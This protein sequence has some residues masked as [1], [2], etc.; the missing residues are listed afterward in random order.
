M[1]RACEHYGSV[2]WKNQV[3]NPFSNARVSCSICFYQKMA[4]NFP[5][6]NKLRRS[7]ILV[8]LL[9]RVMVSVWA[10]ADDTPPPFFLQDGSDSLCLAGADFKR[11]S[12]HTLWYAV[13]S[14]GSYQ[15]HKRTVDAVA[16]ADGCGDG[17]CVAKKS[18]KEADLSKIDGLKVTKCSHCGAKNWNILGDADTGYV[19]THGGESV[20]GGKTSTGKKTEPSTQT[21]VFRQGDAA[22]TAPCDS[23]DVSYTPLQLRFA[24]PADIA[25]MNSSSARL[26]GA[27]A[28]GNKKTV[29]QILQKKD[30]K[31]AVMD[32]NARDWDGLTALIPAASAG[33]MEICK[34]LI[35]QGI[36]VNAADKD[37]ITAL[38]EASIMGQVKIVDLLLEHGAE[39][40]AAAS[41]DVTA[42]WLAASEGKV[43]C[44]KPL[45][46][47]GAVATN[48]RADGITA[49]MTASVGGHAAAV[50]LLLEHG[51]DAKATDR[52]GLTAL[53]NA[54]E[55]GTV[56]V[57][58]LLTVAT[59]KDPAYLNAMSGTS[60][61]SLIIAAAHGHAAA[62]RHLLAA[63][64]N[65]DAV[66]ESGVTALMFAAASNHVEVMKVLIDEGKADLEHRHTNGGTALL[67]ASTGG[68]VD[69]MRL[70]IEK[71]AAVDI[72][73]NDGITPLMAIA[74]FGSMEGQNLIIDALMVKMS[75]A[76]LKDHINLFSHSGGSTVMFATAGGHLENTK[77]LLELG[78]DAKAIA[79]ATPAYLEK[80]AKAIKTGTAQE[81]DPHIDGVTALHVAAQGGHL[82]VVE[83]LI[84][85]VKVDVSV[86]DDEGRTPLLLAIKGNYGEVASALVSAGADP[87]MPFVDDEGET[88]NLLFDAIMVENE[89]FAK[90]LIEN[91]ADLYHKDDKKVSSLLQ[92]SHRGLTDVVKLLLDKHALT[93]KAG[94]LDDASDDGISPLIAAS[95]E[96]HVEV[97]KL[98]IA[99][100]VNVDAK[101]QDQTT[102]LMAAAAR[103]HTEVVK[104]LL[105]V[106]ASV[107]EQ[108]ADGHTALMFAYNG[109][110]QVDTLWERYS[111]YAK[112][113]DES[114]HKDI[115]DNGTG[116]IIRE[117]LDNHIALIELLL[118]GGADPTSKDKEGHTATDFDFHP[119]A[120]ADVLD[121][122][123]KAEK[124]RDE[125]KNEL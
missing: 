44:M 29:Q 47:K 50:Q 25:T 89:E 7:N 109:K 20:G 94:Y 6:F 73:D 53:M 62:V 80:L 32:I 49:L 69:A 115:D 98:L 34:F 67:E 12:I 28:D 65:V 105:A 54:A 19:L 3:L 10:A 58:E 39:V 93:G 31:E 11:C 88:H 30:E 97:V 42:L 113:A 36:D 121:K 13:G 14:P 95:S 116:S 68:A 125:S 104:E 119:D 122:E 48:T 96:G 51:A 5:F 70:L 112:D 76:E 18:C 120:D 15:I 90:L 63:G 8:L 46:N 52:D 75:E 61:T 111:Q 56:A 100:K 33:H 1:I 71:G 123:T 124:V 87:N 2:V 43:D 114:L 106:G 82:E 55:N 66:A 37:G 78:A 99:A 85:S 84:S 9:C 86:A 103:G 38:M 72:K 16:A 92:A 21:C 35:Q 17:L 91:G 41:S 83:F 59:D 81:E 57:L 23:T 24:S 107:N 102:A 108:N 60:F 118:K 74:S 22:M 77:Q 110:N 101:D 117:A 4:L 64:A 45:L 79:R 40:D 26:I 27:A